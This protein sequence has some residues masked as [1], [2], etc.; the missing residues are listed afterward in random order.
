MAPEFI[1]ITIFIA[2]CVGLP[3]LGLVAFQRQIRQ[4]K[5]VTAL[6]DHLRQTRSPVLTLNPWLGSYRTSRLG[7]SD[8]LGKPPVIAIFQDE[9]QLY[10]RRDLEDRL[11]FSPDQVRWFGRPRKYKN[12]MNVLWLHVEMPDGWRIVKLRLPRE[13]T[14]LMVQALKTILPEAL[15]AAYRRQRPYIHAGPIAAHL[16]EQDIYG[17]WTLLERVALYV[18]P[19]F[20]LLLKDGAVE[21]KIP[22]ETIKRVAAV[23]RLDGPDG[24]VRFEAG[25]ETLAF[26]LSGYEAFAAALAEAAKRSLEE[27]LEVVSAKKKKDD[28]D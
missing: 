4:Q 8:L 6:F 3:L 17:A 21:R 27:P 5:A 2:I 1:G 16:A 7:E 10:N 19:T 15:T 23:K 24:M 13:D 22:L 9:I 25:D 28:E 18:M 26:S 14:R 11:A 12:G 20:L